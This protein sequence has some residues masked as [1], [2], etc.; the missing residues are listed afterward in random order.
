MSCSVLLPIFQNCL[1]PDLQCNNALHFQTDPKHAEAIRDQEAS[2]AFNPPVYIK[3][4]KNI[5]STETDEAAAFRAV[6]A[7]MMFRLKV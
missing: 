6:S 1:L 2:A 3:G 4:L 5:D 7:G